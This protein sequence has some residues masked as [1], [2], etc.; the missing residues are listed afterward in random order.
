[1]VILFRLPLALRGLTL[2][3][4]VGEVVVSDSD[5]DEVLNTFD[6]SANLFG[7]GHEREDECDDY[8]DYSKQIY[9]LFGNLDVFNAMYGLKLQG[10][11]I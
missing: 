3:S 9:D 8:D 10:R 7:G 4:K 2:F 6:E 1:M 5:D 11:R